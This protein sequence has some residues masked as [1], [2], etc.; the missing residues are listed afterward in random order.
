[1]TRIR[2]S[3]NHCQLQTESSLPQVSEFA[4]HAGHN[5][6]FS[7]L[8]LRWWATWMWLELESDGRGRN[9]G[10]L[11]R[12]RRGCSRRAA[13]TDSDQVS[14]LIQS[15]PLAPVMNSWSQFKSRLSHWVTHIAEPEQTISKHIFDCLDNPNGETCCI[16][17]WWSLIIPNY[18]R[19]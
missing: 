10:G 17:Y 9:E 4:G 14:W 12:T 2:I 18:S 15:L 11:L 3:G 8:G 19:E 16:E 7:G 13:R 5:S 6:D 1:M